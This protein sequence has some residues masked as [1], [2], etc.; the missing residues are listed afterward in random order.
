MHAFLTAWHE[1]VLCT[2][3]EKERECV[4]SAIDGFLTPTPLCWICLA[5][6]IKVR[7]QQEKANEPKIA[8]PRSNVRAVDDDVHS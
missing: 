1:N 2:W 6:A 5:K 8:D 7:S 4:T 3:C